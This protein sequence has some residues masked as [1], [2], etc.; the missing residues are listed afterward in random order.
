[1]HITVQFFILFILLLA[2][3]S[4]LYPELFNT[5]MTH[6]NNS[7]GIL[8]PIVSAYFAW[9]KKEEL[10][11][12][13]VQGRAWGGVLLCAS[14]LL[15]IISFA[16]GIAFI[17]RI[18]MVSSL[19]G[20]V[21]FT[22]GNRFV[23]SLMFPLLFLLFMVPVP[24]TLIGIVAL[25]LQL[26]ATTISAAIIKALSIPVYQDGNMLYFVQTQLEVA[27]ACSGIR[28]IV[29]L[30]MLSVIFIHV[31]QQ[32][33]QR[34]LIMLLSAIPLAIVANI[35]RVSGTGILAHFYGD[36]AARSFLHESSGLLVFVFGF[37]VL[38][39]EFFLLNRSGKKQGLSP[40]TP[41]NDRPGPS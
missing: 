24:Q 40:K 34:K 25:P 7:H 14:L 35:I 2:V 13:A 37:V 11:S 27:E 22:Y 36:K 5:W 31:M 15:Y 8:V 41:G 23:Q 38:S 32:G 1:M 16:G 21:A 28:S 4:P 33:W 26:F 17:A 19:I 10:Q 18:T 20:L 29:S 3:Y 6:S 30:T 12:L 39:V 9:Q